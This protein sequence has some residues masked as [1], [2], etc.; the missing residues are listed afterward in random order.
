MRR[1]LAALLIAFWLAA[2]QVTLAQEAAKLTTPARRCGAGHVEAGARS[3][4]RADRALSRRPSHQRA[5]GLDIS[6]R[7]CASGPL[8]KGAGNAKLKGEALT[9]AWRPRIGT[10]ASRRSCSFPTC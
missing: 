10:R 7:R 8:G 9:K 1:L 4:A 6:A 5:D 2:P 3:A